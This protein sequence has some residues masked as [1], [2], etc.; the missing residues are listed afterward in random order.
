MMSG[1]PDAAGPPDNAGPPDGLTPVADR[2]HLESELQGRPDAVDVAFRQGE[3]MAMAEGVTVRTDRGGDIAELV[4][5]DGRHVTVRVSRD[6]EGV[7]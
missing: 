7:R 6:V 3:D 1:P 2:G 5:P 4:Y